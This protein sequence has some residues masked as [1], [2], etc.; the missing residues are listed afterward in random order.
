MRNIEDILQNHLCWLNG[1]DDGQCAD[2]NGMNLQGIY[3]SGANL[4]SANLKGANLKGANLKG[5]NLKGA[6]LEEANLTGATLTKGCLK[7]VYLTGAN[8]TGVIFVE[9]VLT[10]VQKLYYQERSFNALAITA[11]PDKGGGCTLKASYYFNTEPPFDAGDISVRYTSGIIETASA[12]IKEWN[13]CNKAL[14]KYHY[15]GLLH[16]WE[17]IE[18]LKKVSPKLAKAVEEY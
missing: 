13:E 14:E 11:Y 18:P 6:N 8:V 2:L 9:S 17:V 16:Y 5:A 4:E 1:Y 12:F 15:S 10:A 3:L 7:Q